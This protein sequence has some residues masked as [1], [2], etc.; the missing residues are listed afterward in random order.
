MQLKWHLSYARGYMEL[1][2]LDEAAAELTKIGAQDSDRTAVLEVKAELH[3]EQKDWA[4]ARDVTAELCRR[5]PGNA[6]WWIMFAYSTRRAGSLNAAEA[7]LLAAERLHP[8]D[9][10]ILFNLGCYACQRGDLS[11]ASKRVH[12]AI[13]LD[14][15]F[16]ELAK[17]DSDLEALRASS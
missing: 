15:K 5:Q 8:D 11:L 16:E 9:A 12:Q 10:T 7:I 2:L 6:G 4:S 14:P 17:T 1:G 13:E 3:Q